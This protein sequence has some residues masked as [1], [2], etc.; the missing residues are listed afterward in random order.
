MV[1]FFEKGLKIESF[2]GT[3]SGMVD[4]KSPNKLA[5]LGDSDNVLMFANLTAN[6]A[7]DEKAR[8]YY[9]ALLET[10]YAM[11]MKVAELPMELKNRLSHRAKAAVRIRAIIDSL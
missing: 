1:A 2:G 10:A 3:D 7:F 11:T 4:W 9:E 8:A 5:H 6:A